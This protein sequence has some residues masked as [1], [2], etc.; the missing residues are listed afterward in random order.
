MAGSEKVVDLFSLTINDGD[1]VSKVDAIIEILQKLGV[2]AEEAMQALYDAYMANLLSV[3]ELEA[4]WQKIGG[5]V[6]EGTQQVVA[7]AEEIGQAEQQMAEETTAATEQVAAANQAMAT[8]VEEALA[9]IQAA[10]DAGMMPFEEYEQK[11]LAALQ[12]QDQVV[13]AAPEFADAFAIQQAA[14]QEETQVVSD[15]ISMLDSLGGAGEA[16]TAGMFSLDQAIGDATTTYNELD[17][18]SATAAYDVQAVGNEAETAGEKVSGANEG[19]GASQYILFQLGFMA[20]SAAQQFFTLGVNAQDALTIIQGKTGASDQQ[21][22]QWTDTL[23]QMG[24][25][26]GYSLDVM[27]QGLDIVTQAQF[28]GAD[29][30]TVLQGAMELAR[31]S[32]SKLADSTN[33]L[34]MSMVAF[35]AKASDA[36]TYAAIL[37]DALSNGRQNI[38]ELTSALGPVIG[39]AAQAGIGFEDLVSAETDFSRSSSNSMEATRGF[40]GLIQALAGDSQLTT[41]QIVKL[42]LAFDQTKFQ[43]L[44]FAG[45]LEFLAK[46]TDGNVQEFTQLIGGMKD[47]QAAMATLDISTHQLAVNADNLGLSFSAV[48]YNSLDAADK[49]YYL[50]Q[51]SGYNEAEFKKLTTGGVNPLNDALLKLD[52]STQ[53]VANRAKQMGLNFDEAKFKTDDLKQKLLDLWDASGHNIDAFAKLIGGTKNVNAAF[54]IMGTQHLSANSPVQQ[55]MSSL[56]KHLI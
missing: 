30:T 4:A 5:A 46:Y 16:A 47:A 12:G 25:K 37:F 49:L 53:D 28:R 3:D 55:H 29:A 11:M 45:K 36:H 17:D 52:L 39:E 32:G 1:I 22:Q 9:R 38:Q 24:L 56:Q 34:A 40:Q 48:K 8:N 50:L 2:S 19:F 31:S 14:V 33:L 44:D 43:T 13:A 20:F 54:D 23:E 6:E 42:G 15:Y 27:A 35:G 51:V 18:A 26:G 41:D 10:Y 21:M 7:A